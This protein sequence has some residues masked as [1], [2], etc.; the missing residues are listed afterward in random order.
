MPTTASQNVCVGAQEL[1]AQRVTVHVIGLALKPDDL[2]KMACL[3]QMTGGAC[4]TRRPPEQIGAAVEE[5]L[6]LASSDAGRIE[7]P[8]APKRALPGAPGQPRTERRD[9][10]ETAGRCASRTLSALPAGA[11]S[12]AGEP[13]S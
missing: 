1:R 7:P 13:G 4:S 6:K 9:G 11:E 3:P 12:G 5:A 10:A 2:V 8:A